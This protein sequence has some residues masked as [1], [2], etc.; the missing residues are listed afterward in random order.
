MDEFKKF[1]AD[2]KNIAYNKNDIS[3]KIKEMLIIIISFLK[4]LRKNNLI[5][6]NIFNNIILTIKKIKNIK[7]ETIENLKK[8]IHER[9]FKNIRPIFENEIFPSLSNISRNSGK[10][11]SKKKYIT[12]SRLKSKLKRKEESKKNKKSK[13][14]NKRGGDVP[15]SHIQRVIVYNDHEHPNNIINVADIVEEANPQNNN[16]IGLKIIYFILFC[17]VIFTTIITEEILFQNYEPYRETLYNI[18]GTRRRR[19]I[20]NLTQNLTQVCEYIFTDEFF[21]EN[22]TDL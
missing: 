15:H 9:D 4:Y 21:Q 12:T 7:K 18:T 5:E 2:I 13:R 20:Q 10:K 6:S 1:G 14:K 17:I 3:E 11:T 19:I 22:G 8:S 16:S